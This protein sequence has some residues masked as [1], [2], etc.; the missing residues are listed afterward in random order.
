MEVQNV[1]GKQKIWGLNLCPLLRG[2][3]YCV[4]ISEGPLSE[5]PLHVQ[6]L[7]SQAANPRCLLGDFVRWYSPRDWIEDKVPVHTTSDQSTPIKDDQ[8]TAEVSNEEEIKMETEEEGGNDI[9]DVP[10]P[11]ADISDGSQ[12]TQCEERDQIDNE[13][14]ASPSRGIEAE[15]SS[16]TADT[17]QTN[18]MLH[19]VNSDSK[20]YGDADSAPGD[21]W[22]DEDWDVIESDVD[23]EEVISDES[24]EKLPKR[25]CVEGCLHLCLIEYCM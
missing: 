8:Q 10:V 12:A 2:L 15:G 1:L 22:E 25:V 20:D 14:E 16:N 21:G 23:R 9:H 17:Q 3:L 18:R 11:S 6:L 4:P 19:V 7:L 13:V 24:E 5:V